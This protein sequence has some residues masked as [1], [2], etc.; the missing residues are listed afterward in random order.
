MQAIIRAGGKQYLV[1]PGQTLEVDLV[2]DAA[3]MLQFEPLLV[4]DGETISVGT[5][6]VA[7]IMV[8]AEVVAEVKGEKLK[9]LKF[10]AKKR[11]KKLTGHR[12]R[13]TQIKISAIGAAKKPVARAA[14]AKPAAKEPVGAAS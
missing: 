3:K 5:P 14:A 6:T 12:Q 11:E 10:K 7:G 13:Y 2:K 4:I 1:R 8:T 9:I